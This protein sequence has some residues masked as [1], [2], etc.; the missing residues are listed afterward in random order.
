VPMRALKIAVNLAL[1]GVLVW[2]LAA[3][4]QKMRASAS[5]RDSIA[6]WATADLLLH[7]QN[8]YAAT[9]SIWGLSSGT[10]FR[11]RARGESS[12]IARFTRSK[13]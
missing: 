2:F 9:V 1:V 12:G 7:R 10:N 6:Y 3:H 8:P 4:E 13:M 11:T 5:G